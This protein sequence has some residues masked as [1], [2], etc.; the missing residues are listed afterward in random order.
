MFTYPIVL[1]TM[2]NGDVMVEFPDVPEALTYGD[3]E[4]FALDW[5][6]DA[7]HVALQSYIEDHEDI[8]RPSRRR[9]GHPVV[10]VSPA[11]GL[12]LVIYQ[13]MREQGISQ[14]RLANMLHCDARQVRRLLDLDHNSTMNQLLDAFAVFGMTLDF[15][16]KKCKQR[17]P[18]ICM[19]AMA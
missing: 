19:S 15:K 10:E 8:P 14:M 4:D 16:P 12:K 17:A 13:A 2:D 6:Q 11:I 1:T 9:E 3:N 5:A 7:L 18:G